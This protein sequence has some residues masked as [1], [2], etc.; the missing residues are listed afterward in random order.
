MWHLANPIV[1][2][3]S[4]R[5]GQDLCHCVMRGVHASKLSCLACLERLAGHGRPVPTIKANLTLSLLYVRK[6]LFHPLL[7]CVTFS[8]RLHYQDAVGRSVWSLPP[9]TG[10][11]CTALCSLGIGNWFTVICSTIVHYLLTFILSVEKSSESLLI[12]PLKERLS[13]LFLGF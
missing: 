3:S 5:R 2:L 7:D 8:V 11:W 1:Y 12:D 13:F 9:R 6:V 10:N 4:S